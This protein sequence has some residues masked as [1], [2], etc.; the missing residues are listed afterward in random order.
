ML[1]FCARD[2]TAY[3][4]GLSS[5]AK[6]WRTLLP[7]WTWAERSVK[8]HPHLKG[9]CAHLGVVIRSHI[10]TSESRRNLSDKSPED[11]A[12]PAAVHEFSHQMQALAVE[13]TRKLPIQTLLKDY[14]KTWNGQADPASL[15]LAPEQLAP[16]KFAGPYFLPLGIHSTPM[17]AV[18][19]GVVFLEE[20]LT[21]EK[22]GYALQLKL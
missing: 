1:A 21:R 7:L 12:A 3:T 15:T 4:Q 18:R 19:M 14:P 10:V 13:A 9:L 6:L 22:V 16:G 11:G 8:D 5:D 2:H 17:H 20:W